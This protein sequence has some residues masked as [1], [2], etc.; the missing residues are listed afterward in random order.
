MP[1]NVPELPSCITPKPFITLG[2]SNDAPILN[3]NVPQRTSFTAY[4]KVS[5]PL[6]TTPATVFNAAAKQ[7][8]VLGLTLENIKDQL[9]ILA[10]IPGASIPG[11]MTMITQ[12]NLTQLRQFYASAKLNDPGADFSVYN[13]I[14]TDNTHTYGAYSALEFRNY[15]DYL[16]NLIFSSS[17]NAVAVPNFGNFDVNIVTAPAPPDAEPELFIIEEYKTSSFLGDYGAGET[18]NTFSLLPGEKHSITIKSFRQKTSTATRSDNVM[19]SFNQS[20]AAEFEN[21][22]QEE[23]Q[24]AKTDTTTSSKQGGGSFGLN[25]KGFSL[26]GNKSKSSG[27]SNVRTANT[28]RLSK[29]L[30]KICFCCRQAKTL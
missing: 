12:Q 24:T 13:H 6:S 20:S 22:L 8:T 17:I 4:G 9:A 10:V 26:G 19:D 15:I 28:S 7:I 30:Q 5:I 18:V 27:S 1:V 2:N 11:Y 29:A 3:Y 23:K 25:F 21:L 16:A 14:P